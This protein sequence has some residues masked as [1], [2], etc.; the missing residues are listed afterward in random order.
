[1]GRLFILFSLISHLRNLVKNIT[2]PNPKADAGDQLLFW[3]CGI[4]H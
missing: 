4:S 1:M 3:N 2:I